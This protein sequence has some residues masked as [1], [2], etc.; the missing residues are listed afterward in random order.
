MDK[1]TNRW[2]PAAAVSTAAVLACAGAVWGDHVSRAGAVGVALPKTSDPAVLTACANLVRALPADLE[3]AHR[4]GA[5]GTDAHVKQRA[6]A[7]GSPATTLRCGVKEPAAITVGGPD[8]TPDHNR[9]ANMG[10]AAFLNWFIDEH[11]HSVTYTTTDRAVYV[12][13]T[14][15]FDSLAQKQSASNALIDLA[16]A[17]VKTVPNKDGEFVDDPAE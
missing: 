5:A 9:Y 15:P 12:E 1:T 16:P 13:V 11:E 4:R 14:V 7:W 2:I 17:I 3:G 8:Y 10:D 6:V